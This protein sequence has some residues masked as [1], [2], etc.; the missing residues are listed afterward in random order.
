[1]SSGSEPTFDLQSHSQN[2]DGELTPAEVVANAAAAGVELFALTDHDNIDGVDEALAAA[3]EHGLRLVAATE[4]SAVHDGNEDLHVL[5]YLVD[6]HE[7]RFRERM[8]EAREDRVVR[9]EAMGGKLHE[10]GFEIDESMLE[11]RRTAGKSIGRPH[12][13][14]AVIAHPANAER[15]RAEEI[16]RVERFIPTY[17]IPG[18]PA[19][20]PRTRPTVEQAIGWIHDAGGIAVWA[21]PF[22]DIKDAN[23]VLATVDRFHEWGLDGVECFYTTHDQQ[24]T[25]LLIERCEQR[26]LLSTGSSDYH[27]PNHKLFSHFRA[28]G[29]Y[30][31]E[32]RLGPIA[33]S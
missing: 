26:G 16:E 5:G 13:A 30:G 12:L 24:Q 29:L 14:A 25:G 28:F 1:M 6:H 11:R 32:P 23:T 4:L 21:H 8:R 2:S 20:L 7:D 15:L 31:H 18:S 9:A 3:A 17:L 19:Y 27:G 22:W 10:L 33:D